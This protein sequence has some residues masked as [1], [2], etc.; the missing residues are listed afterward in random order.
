ML[1]SCQPWQSL[2]FFYLFLFNFVPT[3]FWLYFRVGWMDRYE[4]KIS[5]NWTLSNV[6]GLVLWYRYSN[7]KER[8]GFSNGPFVVI[9]D[10]P[11]TAIHNSFERSTRKCQKGYR[12]VGI[13]FSGCQT[14]CVC[15]TYYA[16]CSDRL[17]CFLQL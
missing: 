12:R 15:C 17:P 11:L 5:G 7:Q 9:T 13:N 1:D 16:G 2:H 10:K 14:V 8:F 6:T 3:R 4:Y